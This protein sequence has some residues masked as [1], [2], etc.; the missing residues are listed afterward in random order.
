MNKS[1]SLSNTQVLQSSWKDYYEPLQQRLNDVASTLGNSPAL[2]D[3]Q[4]EV[5]LYK[6]HLGEFGYQ[7]FIVSK[8]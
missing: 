2:H 7:F 3:I 6:R 4:N 8:R 1:A 5:N